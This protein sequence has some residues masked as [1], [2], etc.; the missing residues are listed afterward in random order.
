VSNDNPYSEAQCKTLKSRPEFPELFGCSADIKAF[1]QN[2]FGLDKKV[3]L[4][5]KA[6]KATSH[7][8]RT[9][10]RISRGG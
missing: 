10:N 3:V 5:A 1:Y 7:Q 4:R 2:F 6:K 8:K 9:V